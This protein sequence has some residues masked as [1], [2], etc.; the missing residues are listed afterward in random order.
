MAYRYFFM[1]M[2]WVAYGYVFFGTLFKATGVH[3]YVAN[4]FLGA[5]ILTVGVLHVVNSL[6][7]PVHSMKS[8]SI[9]GG[10]V[11]AMVQWWYGHNAVGLL[12]KNGF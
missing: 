2:V 8:Y 1:G 9:Y 5:F 11:D 7:I 10:A 6:A 4:W 3:I 12:T